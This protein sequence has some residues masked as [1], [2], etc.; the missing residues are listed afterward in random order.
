VHGWVDLELDR[1]AGDT[2][3]PF[4][5]ASNAAPISPGIVDKVV[6]RAAGERQGARL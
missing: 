1:D 5:C 2:P 3:L 4:A 6:R